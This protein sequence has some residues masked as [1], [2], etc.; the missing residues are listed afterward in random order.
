M[1]PTSSYVDPFVDNIMKGF[2]LASFVRHQKSV[3]KAR[4]AAGEDAAVP[5]TSNLRDEDWKFALDEMTVIYDRIVGNRSV[6]T[7]VKLQD[8]WLFFESASAKIVE[9][10]QQEPE[11]V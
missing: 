10:M 5:A 4:E 8:I 9:V 6:T 1:Y 2:A 3:L 7:Q 11:D